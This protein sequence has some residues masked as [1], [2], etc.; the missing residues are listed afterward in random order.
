MAYLVAEIALFLLIAVVLGVLVGWLVG[1]QKEQTAPSYDDD[2]EVLEGKRRLD[3]C[4]R[5]KAV[6]RRERKQ[7]KE[8]FE[9][10]NKQA[11][12][13]DNDNLIATL[14]AANAQ[15]QALMD[16]VQIRDDMITAL[17]KN[18]KK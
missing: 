4:H 11:S 13:G 8:D 2:I 5:E 9:K 1:K 10:L 16:D 17:E 7:Y 6:L 12:M 14:D 15:I 18:K 3:R